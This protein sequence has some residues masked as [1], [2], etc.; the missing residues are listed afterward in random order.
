MQSPNAKRKGY[1]DLPIAD[2]HIHM[3]YPMPLGEQA[4]MLRGY[5]DYFGCR[6]IA[7]LGLPH[8]V[9]TAADDPANNLKVLYLKDLLNREDPGRR[10]YA[11]GG[12]WHFFD[13]RDTAEGFLRQV[14]D[15]YAL[16]F[17][18]L[19]VL[20]GKPELRARF[21]RSLSDPLLDGV[22]SFC[23]EKTFPVTLHL[24]DPAAYWEPWDNGHPPMYGP[25]LPS[26]EALRQEVDEML[27]AHP[28]LP[29]TLCHFYFMG[30]EPER[31]DRFLNEHPS[32]LLDLT[33]GSEM[34]AGFSRSIG[35]WRAF[36][37]KHRERIL[38][39][40]D[41]DN[42]AVPDT[43]EGYVHNF[44]Y[45]HNLVRNALESAVP[46]RFEDVDWGEL[47]PLF[48]DDETLRMIYDRNFV[49]RFGEE[50]RSADRS[51]AACLASALL[52]LYEHGIL[53][54]DGERLVADSDNLGI[55][56]AYFRE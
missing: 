36:F 17:D 31:A 26:L 1:R 30:D 32:V 53:T 7:L 46:F 28:A 20:L 42:W 27:R 12:L 33:P 16:G 47:L 6:R 39:G 13:G 21:G 3:T 51:A 52:S 23:E 24:G 10:V 40:T 50:P 4:R 54:P 14:R 22:W 18:G 25:D 49:R 15:L 9:R 34:Y 48:P 29:M 55:M 2:S 38:F 37:S 35:E 11:S 5:M 45:P 41:T 8:S 43:E 56:E 44:S 19:K